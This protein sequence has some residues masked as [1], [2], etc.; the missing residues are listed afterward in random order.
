MTNKIKGFTL[1]LGLLTGVMIMIVVCSNRT[2]SDTILIAKSHVSRAV[3]QYVVE[4]GTQWVM[5]SASDLFQ[6]K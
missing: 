4:N 6:I 2:S 5:Q 3:S 1:A